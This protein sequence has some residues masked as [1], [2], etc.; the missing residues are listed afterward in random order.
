MKNPKWIYDHLYEYKYYEEIPQA[1]FDEINANLDKVQ[2][3]EPLVTVV[4]C[5]WNEE[6]NILKTISSM[7]RMHTAYPFEIIVVNNNSTDHTQDTLNRLRI[8]SCFQPVQGWGPARQMGLEQAAGK[9]VLMADADAIYPCMWL[10]RMVNALQ[11][12]GVVCVYGRYSFIAEEGYPRW[13]L[14]I[15]EKMKD[16]V[17]GLRHFKRPY[18]NAFGLSMG[19]IKEYALKVGYVMHMIRGEDGRMCFD[20]MK[21]GKVLQVKSNSAR[22]WTYPRTLKKDGSLGKALINRVVKE[23]NRLPKMFFPMAAHDTKTSANEE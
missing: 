17:A 12:P 20:L 9:Y 5:A 22:I 16:M 11:K 10:E 13:Q 23:I 15:H 14:F 18:L 3:K 19:F 8:K 4:I 1:V 2:S 21:Y 7:S 6:V